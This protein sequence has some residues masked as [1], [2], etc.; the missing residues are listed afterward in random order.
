M[1]AERT[2]LN[3]IRSK[4]VKHTNQLPDEL[5]INDLYWYY[6]QMYV[7]RRVLPLEERFPKEKD[8]KEFLKFEKHLRKVLSFYGVIV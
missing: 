6:E 4:L 8:R 2:R 1:T 7:A 3:K 5:V